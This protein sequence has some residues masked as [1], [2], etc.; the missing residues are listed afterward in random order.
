MKTRLI[1]VVLAGALILLGL[2][3]W[4]QRGPDVAALPD[5][6]A[7]SAEAASLP[8]ATADQVLPLVLDAL[9]ECDARATTACTGSGQ[10][11][12]QIAAEGG[13]ARVGQL[14]TEPAIL[15]AEVLTCVRQAVRRMDLGRGLGTGSLEVIYPVACRDGRLRWPRPAERSRTRPVDLPPQPKP[16]QGDQDEQDQ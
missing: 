14:R 8:G 2:V 7:D 10:L 5:A 11:K 3:V 13:R 6:G 12:F 9:G 15:D 16:T 1:A 4:W